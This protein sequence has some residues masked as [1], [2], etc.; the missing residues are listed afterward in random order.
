M[1]QLHSEHEPTLADIEVGISGNP[2]V[3]Q[4]SY[5]VSP[6]VS[7]AFF[8]WCQHKIVHKVP[9]HPVVNCQDK[10]LTHERMME[11]LFEGGAGTISRLTA[12]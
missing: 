4:G 1:I 2:T 5:S 11:V 6:P 3:Q 10:E 12:L 9:V 8:P 7:N